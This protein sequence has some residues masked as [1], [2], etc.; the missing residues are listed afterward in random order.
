MMAWE[1]IT[2]YSKDF[3]YHLAIMKCLTPRYFK[4]PYSDDFP[5]IAAVLRP[6]TEYFI[7][8]LR[9]RCLIHLEIDWP[10]TLPGWD[11]HERE[12]TDHFGNYTPHDSSAHPILAINLAL[13][14]RCTSVSVD[15]HV[16]LH[17]RY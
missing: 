2:F 16:T 10:S 1:W 12:A 4:K 13:E 9:Q 15:C 8:N 6:S 17:N 3:V 7:E 14:L 5:A 11:I